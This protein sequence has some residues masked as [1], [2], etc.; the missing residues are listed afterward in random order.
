MGDDGGRRQ[1]LREIDVAVQLLFSC[2]PICTQDLLFYKYTQQVPKISPR[3]VDLH[4]VLESTCS[5][6]TEP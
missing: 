3:I 1:K 2:I 5:G 4:V 6:V